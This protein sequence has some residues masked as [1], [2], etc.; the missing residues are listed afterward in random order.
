MFDNELLN[1]ASL[2]GVETYSCNNNYGFVSFMLPAL[3]M[4]FD[5]TFSL[6]QSHRSLK[7]CQPFSGMSLGFSS[8]CQSLPSFF[9]KCRPGLGLVAGPCCIDIVHG[10]EIVAVK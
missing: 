9:I 6:G 4:K 8:C 2:L 7:C 1:S 5:Q 10:H 3:D